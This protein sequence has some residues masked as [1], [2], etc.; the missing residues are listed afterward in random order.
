MKRI[1]F[2]AALLLAFAVAG[3]AQTTPPASTFHTITTSWN[4]PASWTG[5]GLS[6]PCNLPTVA[7]FCVTGYTQTITSPPGVASTAIVTTTATGYTWTPGGALY[8]G[9]YGLSVVADWLNGSGVAVA[10]A[11]L[12]GTVTVSCPFTAAPPTGLTTKVS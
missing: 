5:I 7:T 8:C 10:S 11:P 12:A 4:V 3:E 9:T 6:V 1:L 2:L